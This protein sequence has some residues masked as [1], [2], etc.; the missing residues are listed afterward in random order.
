M[1]AIGA[2]LALALAP[3]CSWIF[4]DRPPR[5]ATARATVPCDADNV[6]PVL[7]VFVALYSAAVV[8]WAVDERPDREDAQGGI[9]FAYAIPAV[10]FG[11][12]AISGLRRSDRCEDLHRWAATVPVPAHAGEVGHACIPTSD[13]VGICRDSWC[14]AGRCTNV[15]PLPVLRHRCAPWL[16]RGATSPDQPIP[17]ECVP[18]RPSAGG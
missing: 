2:A 3:G 18:F 7:D 13:G 9:P 16:E 10:L 4:V 11:W 5:T 17:S 6:S 12:S 8:Q 15:V 1:R 14:I